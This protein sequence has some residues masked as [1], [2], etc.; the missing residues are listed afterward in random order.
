MWASDHTVRWLAEGLQRE[1]ASSADTEMVLVALEALRRMGFQEPLQQRPA[2]EATLERLAGSQWRAPLAALCRLLWLEAPLGLPGLGPAMQELR[3]SSR[4]LGS[5]EV[6]ILV[7]AL[8][9][10]AAR[11]RPV[12]KSDVVRVRSEKGDVQAETALVQRLLA[13]IALEKVRSGFSAEELA[14]TVLGFA[15]LGCAN[16]PAYKKLMQDILV[17]RGELTAGELDRAKRVLKRAGVSLDASW[18]AAGSIM[19]KQRSGGIATVQTFAPQ[20]GHERD[21]ESVLKGKVLDR[22]VVRTSPERYQADRVR[23]SY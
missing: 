16:A 8:H 1:V 11:R 15:E 14:D 21:E 13:R 19:K 5:S 7:D 18:G 22:E 9:R 17:R 10:R 23:S 20:K 6:A 3:A 12:E 4:E 2:I